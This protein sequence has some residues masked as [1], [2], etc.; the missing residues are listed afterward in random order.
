MIPERPLGLCPGLDGGTW[1]K[2]RKK[3]FNGSLVNLLICERARVD[4]VRSQLFNHLL[5]TGLV[6]LV[7]EIP[8]RLRCSRSR[9]S[10]RLRRRSWHRRLLGKRGSGG[11][12]GHQTTDDARGHA[13]HL[14]KLDQTNV[15]AE[16]PSVEFDF[17]DCVVCA[18]LCG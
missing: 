16:I 12:E 11:A 14:L 10:D 3:T 15:A 13:I 6:Q 5:E 1:T 18:P 17:F 7:D 2:P 4:I 8:K 9:R